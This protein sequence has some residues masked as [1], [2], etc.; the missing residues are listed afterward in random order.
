[1]TTIAITW[2]FPGKTQYITK[3]AARSNLLKTKRKLNITTCQGF[4]SVI[5]YMSDNPLLQGLYVFSC[6]FSEISASRVF[7][8]DYFMSSRVFYVANEIDF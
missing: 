4:L 6:T 2:Y 3:K 7:E 8:N 1:M 5:S